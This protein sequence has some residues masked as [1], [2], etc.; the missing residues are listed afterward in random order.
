MF[1][2]IHKKNSLG[3]QWRQTSDWGHSSFPIRTV[4]GEY[5][6]A[7]GQFSAVWCWTYNVNRAQTV[8]RSQGAAA[9]VH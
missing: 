9:S 6:L 1:N 4:P 3:G 7:L 8:S 5:G 2:Y